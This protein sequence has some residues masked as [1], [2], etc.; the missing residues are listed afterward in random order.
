MIR[1]LISMVA[2]LALAASAEATDQVVT[3]PGDNG[4]P[5]QLR[6]KITASQGSGGGTIT[7]AV[8]TTTIVLMNGVLPA[9]TGNIAIDGANVITLSGN[10]ASPVFQVNFGGT[11]TL[12][13]LTI[14][15]AFNSTGDGGAIRNGSGIGNGG[16]LNINS[17][18]FLGNQVGA[19]FSGGAILSY[20]PLNISNSE[21]GSNKAGN[22]GAIFP[23]F[24]AAVTTITGCNFHDNVTL[25]ATDGWGGAMLLWDGV[26]VT[27]TNSQVVNNAAR[28]GGGIYV[29]AHSNLTITDS[30]VTANMADNGMTG[31]NYGGGILNNGT[32]SLTNVTLNGNEVVETANYNDTRGGGGIANLAGATATVTKGAINNN[33]GR[34]GGGIL[35]RGGLTI[36]DI[37][38]DQNHGGVGGAILNNPAASEVLTV[39]GSTLSGNTIGVSEFYVVTPRGAAIYNQNG[40]VQMTNST[41]SGN[42]GG[43]AF[44]DHE[45]NVTLV[46]V[47]MANNP[48]GGLGSDQSPNSSVMNVKNTVAANNG[49]RNCGPIL[50]NTFTGQFNLATDSTCT[51]SGPG[52]QVVPDANLGALAPNG[53]LTQTHL[54]G[55][56]S[57]V[58]DN[59]TSSGAPA[60][61]QRGIPRPQGAADDIGAVEV[62]PPATPTPTPTATPGLVANVSTRLPVGT[63]DNVLI[64]GFIVQGPPD[65]SKKIIV[66][67]IGPSLVSFGVADALTNPTLEIHDANSAT[68]ATNNDWRNTQVGGLITADQSMEIA[69]SGLAPANDL[70][71]AIIANLGPGSYTAVVRGLGDTTGTG[72]V[73][74]YDLSASSPVRLANIAT[75]GLIQPGDQLMIA[76]FI[77][78]NGQLRAVVRAIGPSLAAF[79]INNA[80]TDTTLQLRDQNGAIVVE[81]DDWKLRSDGSSQQ[82]ELEATGL[83]PSDDREAAFVTTLQ[84]GQYTAQVRGKPEGTGIGVVQVY[85]LQ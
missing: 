26:G 60:T 12:N 22:G 47:T 14:T 24:A 49:S 83:Q 28:H 71:S 1:P 63:G 4:G 84:P 16:T 7:F 39:T 37:T 72:V 68:I 20:G 85:F 34:E 13:N 27:I 76:G 5:N 6:S 40:K 36:T 79:G 80:L 10:N 62:Q 73:D 8:G 69:N 64:E 70:E 66:R 9:V 18:K 43:Q 21:F 38:M 82:A 74:A 19:S 23:R 53:G 11:L 61:D 50:F 51:W 48:N 42:A 31:N 41:L 45:G 59:A 57:A 58:I 32:L 81:D 17:C 78:Q 65:A 46:N 52:N 56:G 30:Q 54:P 3:D 35:N 55:P 44:T 25:S 75:R 77:I 2:L 67:A 29:F 15:H 33:K